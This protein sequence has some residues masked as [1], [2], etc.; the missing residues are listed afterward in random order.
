M[1]ITATVEESFYMWH[2]VATLRR[3]TRILRVGKQ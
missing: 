3:V 1:L 2:V